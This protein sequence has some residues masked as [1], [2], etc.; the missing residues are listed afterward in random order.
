MAV[1]RYIFA[2]LGL[3]FFFGWVIIGAKATIKLAGIERVL[4]VPPADNLLFAS[5]SSTVIIV[6][7]DPFDLVFHEY[8][9]G[10]VCGLALR[11]F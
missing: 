5:D 1:L 2:N 11:I 10:H 7:F 6:V 9:V 4:S 8:I 3:E